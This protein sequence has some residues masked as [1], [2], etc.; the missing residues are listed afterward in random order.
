MD[1]KQIGHGTKNRTR[2]ANKGTKDSTKKHLTS[3]N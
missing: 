3:G 1:F 2:Q